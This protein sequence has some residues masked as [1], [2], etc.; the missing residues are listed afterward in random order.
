MFEMSLVP[1]DAKIMQRIVNQGI[2]S[3]LEGFTKSNFE[4]DES[5]YI[6]R[7]KCEIHPD[8]MQILIRRLLEDESEEAEEWADV[9]VYMAYG[10]EIYL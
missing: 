2:D 10:A 5:S 6:S 3:R 7:L 1:K 4:W 8:E 9:I